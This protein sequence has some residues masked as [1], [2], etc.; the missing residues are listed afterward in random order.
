M[1]NQ[2]GKGDKPRPI[3]K[4]VFDENYSQIK[5]QSNN[6]KLEQLQVTTKRNK[7]IYKY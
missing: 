7:T 1:N 4:N 6:K 2:A 5:W 3:N